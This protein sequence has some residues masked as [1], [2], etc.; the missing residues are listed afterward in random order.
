MGGGD[1]GKRAMVWRGVNGRSQTR[2]EWRVRVLAQHKSLLGS[3]GGGTQ[4]EKH[5]QIKKLNHRTG[6]TIWGGSNFRV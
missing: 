2:V 5:V 3:S 1:G 4:K 6:L